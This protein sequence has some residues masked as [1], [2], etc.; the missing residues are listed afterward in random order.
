[1]FKELYIKYKTNQRIN[2]L[3]NGKVEL[4]Q[5]QNPDD[6]KHNLETEG[7]HHA[8][9]TQKGEKYRQLVRG[10]LE[11]ITVPEG[12]RAADGKSVRS[13]MRKAKS[14]GY[15]QE[16]VQEYV[17]Y[18]KKQAIDMLKPTNV[19][20]IEMKCNGD[21][22]LRGSQ[23]STATLHIDEKTPEELE[24]ISGQYLY[25][26]TLSINSDSN[27]LAVP[28][29]FASR[30]ESQGR[31]MKLKGEETLDPKNLSYGPDEACLTIFA[32]AACKDSNPNIDPT[33]HTVP[34]PKNRIQELL[35]NGKVYSNESEAWQSKGETRG[36]DWRN[37][38][39][40]NM[41]F[42]ETELA[43]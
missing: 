39:I 35:Q 8:R 19:N 12:S 42:C 11:D 33:I 4:F 16:F 43:R 34:P 36:N 15:K 3:K 22:T 27:T 17:N 10:M 2:K 38:A 14:K 41:Q 26:A 20:G 18:N 32:D 29:K 25:T 9:L 28:K 37:R 21:I 40:L 6:I 30:F 23:P 7:V 13:E 24:I 5:R 1:M 31:Y